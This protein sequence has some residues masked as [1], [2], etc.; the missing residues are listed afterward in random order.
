MN[1]TSTAR[2]WASGIRGLYEHQ[3]KW[4]MLL[5]ESR[6]RVN[7]VQNGTLVRPEY[8]A[9]GWRRVPA[10]LTYDAYGWQCTSTTLYL[11]TLHPDDAFISKV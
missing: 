8:G 11:R 6:A 10:V 2:A 7:Y 3:A 5:W 4:R 1:S 9:D